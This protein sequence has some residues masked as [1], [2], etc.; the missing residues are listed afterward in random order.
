MNPKALL[1][2]PDADPDEQARAVAALLRQVVRQARTDTAAIARLVLTVPAAWG[3]RRHSL[4][5]R[6]AELAGLPRP[7][8][9]AEPVAAAAYAATHTHVAVG[10]CVLVCD[11]GAQGTHVS[12]V[13]RA[14]DGWS[15]LATQPVPAA[16]GDRLQAALIDM[17]LGGAPQDQAARDAVG[18]S[19]AVA[20]TA[21]A[22]GQPA[23]I[24]RPGGAP[25]VVQ[26]DELTSL[27]EQAR[28]ELGAAITT[29]VDAGDVG[30]IDA[31]VVVGKPTPLLR[32]AE[33]IT[34]RLG[35]TPVELEQPLLALPLG[36]LELDLP[37][38]ADVTGPALGAGES[39]ITWRS[40]RL[41]DL[42]LCGLA[43]IGAAA[44]MAVEL[45]YIDAMEIDFGRLPFYFD[46]AVHATSGLIATVALINGAVAMAAVYQADDHSSG[47]PG[48]SAA[49]AG[50]ALTF[51]AGTGLV[52]AGLLGLL[53][54]GRFGSYAQFTPNFLGAALSAAAIPAVLC[55]LLGILAPLVSAL[56]R[57]RW[58]D[59]LRHPAVAPLLAAAAI[60]TMRQGN[61][62]LWLVPEFLHDN[63]MYDILDIVGATLL[64]VATALTL[65]SGTAARLILGGVLVIGF[66]VAYTG[67]AVNLLATVYVIA[68]IGWYL[69]QFILL[70]YDALPAHALRR[71]TL[72]W[73]APPAQP[74]S[75]RRDPR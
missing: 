2:D 52:T 54:E 6:A 63:I 47:M 42:V 59:R 22:A 23:A 5:R 43:V 44:I 33:L 39:M 28:R 4:L 69:R 38:R 31:A 1:A 15:L 19:V 56:R 66:N 45:S 58:A 62:H 27:A 50:R 7:Q 68:V 72:G 20:M 74:G 64:A 51:C 73:A 65:V 11:V 17:V 35:V 18:A 71:F 40:V 75:A 24:S 25:V 55:A 61:N 30:G 60:I 16:T 48:R 26:V 67:Y 41:G 13:E 49:K 53:G 34:E 9:V 37:A 32:T 14:E 3:P 36:A 21:L 12:L 29:V 10:D 57:L 46:E 8:I 70:G